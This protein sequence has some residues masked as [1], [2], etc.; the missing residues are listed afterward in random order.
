MNPNALF[1]LLKKIE[2]KNI[3]KQTFHYFSLKIF[4]LPSHRFVYFSYVSRGKKRGGQHWLNIRLKVRT[5]C[6]L[7]SFY[8][9]WK[10]IGTARG[11]MGW[12]SVD[13]SPSSHTCFLTLTGKWA[14]CGEAGQIPNMPR[15]RLNEIHLKK[16]FSMLCHYSA[17]HKSLLL[18]KCYCCHLQPDNTKI[19]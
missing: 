2:H 12:T 3:R 13:D 5:K 18:L 17:V 15:V 6:K 10:E 8:N 14:E 7:C 19:S 9:Q 4:F 11:Q 1:L 16:L